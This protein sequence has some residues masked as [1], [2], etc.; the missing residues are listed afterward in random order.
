MGSSEPELPAFQGNPQQL[1]L[2]S[3]IWWASGKNPILLP[4]SF[5]AN[6]RTA[7]S[8]FRERKKRFLGW[9]LLLLLVAQSCVTLCNPMDSSFPVLHRW[10]E[11]GGDLS[12]P[13]TK[14]SRIASGTAG[15]G[16]CH[17]SS[18]PILTLPLNMPPARWRH[19]PA[20]RR[21]SPSSPLYSKVL[22]GRIF[23]S[24]KSA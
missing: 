14:K 17:L 11:I 18:S 23:L 1:S 5:R 9:R 10:M 13:L 3:P 7:Q 20:G 24:H 15:S 2:K 19:L 12:C 22:V 8:C 4:S 16:G 6:H 21:E